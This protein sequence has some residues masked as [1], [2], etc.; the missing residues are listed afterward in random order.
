MA[1]VAEWPIGMRM[2]MRDGDGAEASVRASEV[3]CSLASCCCYRLQF[4]SSSPHGV[5]K[6]YLIATI[7]TFICSQH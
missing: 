4:P 7:I 3:G 5:C 1:T 6:G 2:R